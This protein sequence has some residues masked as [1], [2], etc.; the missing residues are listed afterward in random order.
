MSDEVTIM[1]VDFGSH[2]VHRPQECPVVRA[3]LE[4]Y[5]SI[6]YLS[7]TF[8]EF[9]PGYSLSM[10]KLFTSTLRSVLEKYLNGAQ[11]IWLSSSRC[12]SKI[13]QRNTPHGILDNARVDKDAAAWFG[14]K[15]D[16]NL[17]DIV[18]RPV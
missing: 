16:G 1:R 5:V 2:V 15:V 6:E 7:I 8:A 13:L 11:D 9:T 14:K 10:V 12:Y 17:Q 18:V 4:Y 3:E